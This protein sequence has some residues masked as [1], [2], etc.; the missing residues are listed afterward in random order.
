M[1][2]EFF[3]DEY[4]RYFFR[5]SSLFFGSPFFVRCEAAA[6]TFAVN[7]ERCIKHTARLMHRYK[8][9][10]GRAVVCAKLIT[11][12]IYADGMPLGVIEDPVRRK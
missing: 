11:Q 10:A 2:L 5:S 9:N 4:Q 8:Y 1:Q 7:P 12:R 6:L 3:S